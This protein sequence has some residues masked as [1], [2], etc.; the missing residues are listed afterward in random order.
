MTLDDILTVTKGHLIG[1]KKVGEI[2]SFQIDSR[3]I[4]KGDVFFAFVGEHLDGHYFV[5]EAINRGA[6]LVIVQKKM[7]LSKKVPMIQVQDPKVA[8]QQLAQF[9][10]QKYSEIPLIAIT[11]SAGK[12]TTK[13]LTYHLLNGTY[14]VLKTEGNHNNELGLPLTLSKLNNTYDLAVVELGM[15]HS[16]EIERLSHICQP[17]LA[18]I[19]NIGN[20]HIGNLGSKKN[21]LKA[22]L[23]IIKGMKQGILL[24]KKEDRYLK[25]IKPLPHFSIERLGYDNEQFHLRNIESFIDHTDFELI[26]EDTCYPIVFSVPGIHLLTDLLFAIQIAL[27][28]R[29]PPTLIAERIIQYRPLHQRMSIINL[30]NTILIDDCYNASY[31]SFVGSLDLLKQDARG[32]LLVLG[33]ILELGK[34]SDKIHRLLQ[35]KLK[36]IKNATILLTGD[37]MKKIF[38]KQKNWFYFNNHQEIIDYLEKKEQIEEIVF[39]KGSRKLQLEI[40]R[41]YLCRK[42]EK[43]EKIEKSTEK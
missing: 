33:D 27:L 4:E 31:E 8:L 9:L 20:A 25:K 13:E 19:T 34:Y 22:K 11:G 38:K 30:A 7:T 14:H 43:E 24:L 36:T 3:K 5:N 6:S 1:S 28:F 10:R 32:K 39:L 15:N 2:K 12:S 17:D 16:G 42:L 21:I 26:I 40:I 29:V 37:A 41:D 23:E 35:K 18:V